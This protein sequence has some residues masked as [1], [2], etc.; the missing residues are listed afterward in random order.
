MDERINKEG[1]IM[2]NVVLLELVKKWEKQAEP[3]DTM[4]AGDEV[5]N[6]KALAWDKGRNEAK[7]DC[8]GD[9]KTLIEIIGGD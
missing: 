1:F 6:A 2:R 9:L 3:H 5:E 4:D 8:V 7:R